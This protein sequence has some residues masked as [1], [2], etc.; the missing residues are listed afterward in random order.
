MAEID[1]QIIL[2][3]ISF[4]WNEIPIKVMGGPVRLIRQCR[5]IVYS[6]PQAVTVDICYSDIGYLGMKERIS[7]MQD[8]NTL[9]GKSFAIALSES[10]A[11]I[12]LQWRASSNP[13]TQI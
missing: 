1:R 13:E 4:L 7:L 8:G 9:A 5:Q 11:E 2:P 6:C 3:G 12:R 10:L